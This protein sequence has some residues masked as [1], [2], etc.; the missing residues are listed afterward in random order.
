[1]FN[2]TWQIIKR[3]FKIIKER[4]KSY[5][6]VMMFVEGISG[7]AI[8]LLATYLP[9]MAIN[10]LEDNVSKD[11]IIKNLLVFIAILMILGIISNAV[12]GICNV[13]FL[14]IRVLEF[15]RT[16][17]KFQ[18]ID[19]KYLED[20]KFS[21][22]FYES[23][24]ALNGDNLGF[25]AVYSNLLRI[26]PK[27]VAII[28]YIIVLVQYSF[29]LAL[30][31][32]VSSVLS[33]I[34][35]RKISKYIA[36]RKEER[37]RK[38]RQAEYFSNVTYD[39]SYGKEIRVN[40]LRDK[41][42]ADYMNKS[43]E[44][45]NLHTDIAKKRFAYS[46][47]EVL[48]LFIQDIFAYYFIIKGYFDGK[49]TLG[50]ISLLVG[51]TIA[52]SVALRSVS[53]YGTTLIKDTK[54]SASYFNF[55]DNEEYYSHTGQKTSFSN[56][57]D[58]EIE[59]KNVSFKYP[60]T[61]KWILKNFNFKIEKKQK[62]ALVGVN[63][64][65]KSTIIKLI[66]GLYFADEGEILINGINV[67]EF[68]NEEYN[69]LFSV[70]Y[71]DI[72]VYAGSILENVIGDSTNDADVKRGKECLEQIGLKEKIESLPHKYDTQ[73]LKIIDDSGVELSGG[74]KQKIAIARALYKN[75]NIVILD[76]PTSAL[77]ALAELEIYTSFDRLVNGKTA[78]YISHR[79][80]STKFCDKIAFFDK[81][82]LAEY[83]THEELMKNRKGY[84]EMFEIQG[85]Y[86]K[87]GMK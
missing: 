62:L 76:E 34:A 2:S 58:L 20:P 60:N 4:K 82:G 81:N 86:Y 64:A 73:M 50:E 59:F 28:L 44:V 72:N 14:G 17:D 85:K 7:G 11:I 78:I 6:F 67:K 16:I 25:Q 41:I 74:Q 83:G 3:Q 40:N 32:V 31:C 37:A 55:I 27:F 5:L 23:V 29:Y 22:Y 70:V 19:Y 18:T 36:S 30:I 45:V 87:E 9:M 12:K 57:E 39:F 38:E 35:G 71:Q 47:L 48:A 54:Y 21:D 79:L 66:T 51:I 69:R 84:Y 15:E 61:D 80:S 13:N 1:M 77:D 42:L 10:N 26:I 53:D 68:R 56:D 63:G 46:L 52:L 33:I 8:P 65:G 24:T 49:F 75:A 43:Q